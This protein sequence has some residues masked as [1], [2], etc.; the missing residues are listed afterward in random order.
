M[1]GAYGVRAGI[2]G[3][4]SQAVRVCGPHRSR[5][6]GL[7][8]TRLQRIATA[9]ALNV[10]RLDAWLGREPR[11]STRTYASSAS[12]QPEPASHRIRQRYR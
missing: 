8:K 1:A 12:W 6:V 7:A 11:A 2:E 5:Y 10:V 4:L 9:A 3:C